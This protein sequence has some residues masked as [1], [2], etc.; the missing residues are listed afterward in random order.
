MTTYGRPLGGGG[1]SQ[2]PDG[3]YSARVQEML[4]V[5]PALTDFEPYKIGLYALGAGT[6]TVIVDDSGSEGGG[7]QAA[8][9]NV[10]LSFAGTLFQH[11]KSGNWAICF[12]GV[13]VAPASGQ[14]NL[15]GII[16]N[17]NSHSVNAGS[18]FAVD[19][20]HWTL[21]IA[22]AA[23][24]NVA[25]GIV[26]DGNYHNFMLTGNGTT[27]SLYVDNVL[28][29]STTTLT[30]LSDEGMLPYISATTAGN[31]LITKFIY[32]FVAQ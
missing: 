1:S 21:Q 31:A 7:K 28:A 5:V 15:I 26:A 17:A 13:L 32:G 10:P 22:G 3:W 16:N 20:T 29:A 4:A 9:S 6:S 19:T 2:V 25:G 24:T 12:R 11:P 18:I 14:T 8:A 30:N 27:V 23:N